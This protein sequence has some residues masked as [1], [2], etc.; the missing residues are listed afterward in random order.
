MCTA[1]PLRLKESPDTSSRC[2]ICAKCTRRSHVRR[3]GTLPCT[4][5]FLSSKTIFTRQILIQMRYV[6]AL[7]RC[8]RLGTPNVRLGCNGSDDEVLSSNVSPTQTNIHGL[9]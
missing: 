3:I 2:S 9:L 8:H 6:R 7:P 4:K 1:I 5:T